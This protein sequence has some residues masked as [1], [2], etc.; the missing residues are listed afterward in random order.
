[1]GELDW[2]DDGLLEG[3]LGL[4]QSGHIV[5]ANVRLLCQNGALQGAPQLLV[6][7]IAALLALPAVRETREA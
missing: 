4:L 7:F 3:F 6:I 2:E 5:P 1:M